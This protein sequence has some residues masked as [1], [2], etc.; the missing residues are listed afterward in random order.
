M[1]VASCFV[2]P[3][4]KKGNNHLWRHLPS[5]LSGS[6]MASQRSHPPGVAPEIYIPLGFFLIQNQALK[7]L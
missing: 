2:G 7:R 5:H 6:K 4:L 3:I 1:G